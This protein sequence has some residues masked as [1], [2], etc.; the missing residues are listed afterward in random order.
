MASEKDTEVL[1]YALGCTSP[2]Q[3]LKIRDDARRYGLDA[4]VPLK[5]VVK[6]VRGREQRLLVPAVTQIILVKGTLDAVNDYL[7]HAHHA[8]FIK[9][10][11]YSN[12][13]DC[14]TVSLQAMEN[15][16]AVTEM[17]ERRVTYFRPEEISLREGDQ[18]RIRGGFYDGREGVI[19]RIKGKRNR[20]L[21]V[22][23]PG[24]LIAAV[25]LAPEMI[26]LEKTGVRSQESVDMRQEMRELKSKD[27]DKDR[28]LLFDLAHRLLFEFSDKYQNENE[29]Y[30]LRSEVERTQGRIASFR[31]YTPAT[32]AEL[33]LPLYMA[34]VILEDGL[35]EAE[36]RLRKAVAGLKDNSLLRIRCQI[37][38]AVLAKDSTLLQQVESVLADWRTK[39]LSHN[40]RSV[41]DEYTLLIQH[42][43]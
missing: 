5:Y 13:K 24:V 38:L 33:A 29:Y 8:V 34:S 3:E 14:L 2:R 43:S 6:K 17:T 28:R 10:S 27:L 1:W 39:P 35:E 16:M 25:E 21:V 40:Q 7:D 11:T 37:Y 15:F 32:E 42:G 18:I 22:Q 12:H 41:L 23:I 36:A 26:E 31:G 4:F 19:M 9:R 30:L 20:H